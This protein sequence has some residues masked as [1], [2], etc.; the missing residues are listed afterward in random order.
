MHF[1]VL[2][3]Q[4]AYTV[5]WMKQGGPLPQRAKEFMGMLTITNAVPSDSGTYVCTVSNL[6]DVVSAYATVSVVCK[7]T[8]LDIEGSR[9]LHDFCLSD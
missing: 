6:F 1:H 8:P 4:V 2:L 7:L 3:V 5:A 9:R